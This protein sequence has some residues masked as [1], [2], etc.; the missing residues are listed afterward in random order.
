MSVTVGKITTAVVKGVGKAISN[1][2]KTVS[3][4]AKVFIVIALVI[5]LLGT[6]VGSMVGCLKGA[7]LDAEEVQLEEADIYQAVS[8]VYTDYMVMVQERIKKREEELVV[9]YT[10]SIEEKAKVWVPGYWIEVK[11]LKKRT[12]MDYIPGP[13]VNG[14]GT[15]GTM[16]MRV[17][18]YY[19]TEKKWVEGYWKEES[20]TKDVC[21]AKICTQVNPINMSYI[22]AYL[23]VTEEDILAGRQYNI[24]IK[25]VQKYLDYITPVKEQKKDILEEERKASIGDE[26][27]KKCEILIYNDILS[28]N[29][30]ADHYFADDSIKYEMFRVSFEMYLSIL[31]SS[32]LY[33]NVPEEVTVL[34]HDGGM[35]IP[36]YTQTDYKNVAY[37]NGTIAS[38]GCAL[39]CMAM[40]TSYLKDMECTP[41]DILALIGNRYYVLGAGLAWSMLEDCAKYYGL[42]C[43]N[44][45]KNESKV[46]EALQKGKP[47]IA[48]VGAGTFTTSG[49]FIVIRGITA[50]GHFLV[51]D[52]NM[53]NYI[54]YG[55]D[56][57]KSETVC[58]EAKN[59][60]CFE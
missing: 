3:A 60:W 50:D 48:S 57:F 41:V 59:F 55:T 29:D 52:P 58:K 30:I 54:K 19:D 25:K 9:M 12:V 6:A 28:V 24:D 46:T 53:N 13:I 8:E 4:V 39:V 35:N 49:H 56:R 47:V 17:E 18:T 20:V 26:R 27:Y 38:S 44:L 36:H 43:T 16:V 51:N 5:V 37:G 31:G 7:N 10:E 14:K 40:V 45:G 42:V 15:P 11:V 33:A 1:P 23:T 2:D 32:G 34:Y 22:L 21:T